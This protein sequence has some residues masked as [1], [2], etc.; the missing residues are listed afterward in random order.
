MATR[1]ILRSCVQEE[2][3]QSRPFLISPPDSPMSQRML[4]AEWRSQWAVSVK[5]HVSFE[6]SGIGRHWFSALIQM[7]SL[8]ALPVW[9]KG[10]PTH[11]LAR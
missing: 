1:K 2:G 9:L 6:N 3:Q 8:V 5:S 4:T 7:Y 11:L 10:S